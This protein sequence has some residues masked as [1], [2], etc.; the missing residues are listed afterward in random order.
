MTDRKTAHRNAFLLAL[1]MVSLAI[2]FAG[3]PMAQ[4]AISEHSYKLV[5][6]D[7]W[8]GW[9][10][11]WI[12]LITLAYSYGTGLGTVIPAQNYQDFWPWLTISM[13]GTGV[14]T[15]DYN[16][17]LARGYFTC[18]AWIIWPILPIEI[19][20]VTLLTEVRCYSSTFSYVDWWAYT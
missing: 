12:K 20:F 10:F 4:A 16:R 6:S 17:K 9:E 7:T 13:D 2:G 1:V 3:M 8:F 14:S 5:I 19:K 11:G 15:I 18:I